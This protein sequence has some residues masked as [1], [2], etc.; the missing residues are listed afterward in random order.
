MKNQYFGDINDYRTYGLLRCLTEQGQLTSA[1]CWMLTA[2]DGRSDGRLIGYLQDPARWRHYDPTLFDALHAAVFIEGRRTI[3]Q[4]EAKGVLAGA[5]CYTPLLTDKVAEREAYFAEFLRG[6][7]GKTLLFFDADNGMEV[8]S[9]PYGRKNSAKYLYWRELT[10]ATATES[11]VLVYQYF[12][13]EKRTPFVQRLVAEF[14]A[15]TGRECIYAFCTS[16]VV[17]FLLMNRLQETRL[18]R[19]IAQVEQHWQGQI[20]VVAY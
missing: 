4:I 17:F 19:H 14:K 6:A 9:C 11:A 20:E 7:A 5:W 3:E 15:R 13:R 12:R 2:D 18:R 1:V 10:L 8:P 16:R